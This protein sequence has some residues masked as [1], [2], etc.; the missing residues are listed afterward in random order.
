MY[1]T[2]TYPSVPSNSFDLKE[3]NR[4]LTHANPSL[5]LNPKTRCPSQGATNTYLAHLDKTTDVT[6][7]PP[8]S[9]RVSGCAWR[10]NVVQ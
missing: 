2:P 5:S 10:S 8:A 6:P 9:E 3:N 7:Q 1:H 4:H